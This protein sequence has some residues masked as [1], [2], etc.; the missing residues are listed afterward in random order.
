MCCL[1]WCLVS[2]SCLGFCGVEM[3][4]FVVF[5]FCLLGCYVWKVVIKMLWEL[6]VG[7]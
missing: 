7:V 5:L 2:L 6:G 1:F 4:R 3:S